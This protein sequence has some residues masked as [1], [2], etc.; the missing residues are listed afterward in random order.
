[1]RLLVAMIKSV[2]S[3]YTRG[4]A[5][6]MGEITGTLPCTLRRARRWRVRAHMIEIRQKKK[7]IY[8]DFH[9]Y[10]REPLLL[11]RGNAVSVEW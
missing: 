5:S 10:G 9:F 11:S 6:T 2:L 3:A 4:S 8:V 1:V 7:T